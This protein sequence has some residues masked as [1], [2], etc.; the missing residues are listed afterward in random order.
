LTHYYKLKRTTTG[1]FIMSDQTQYEKYEKQEKEEE[2]DYEKQQEKPQGEKSWDEKYRRDPLGTLTWAL[3]LIWAGIALLVHNLG[4]L[5]SFGFLG[6]MEP[7]AL[8]FVGA[9]LIVLAMVVYR[10]L[11]PE[12]RRPLTG[13]I[14]L[15][16]ILIG[17]GLGDVLGWEIVWAVIIIAIGVSLL[18]GG[19]L[20]RK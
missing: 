8:I 18:L 10:F 1:G 16:F 6:D 13:N 3:V 5:E 17:I 20:R 4:I 9:G 12:Y 7:M 14:V 19:F 11:N 15:G 2:K